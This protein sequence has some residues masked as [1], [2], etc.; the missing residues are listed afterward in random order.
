MIR[1]QKER[2]LYSL[3][4]TYISSRTSPNSCSKDTTRGGEEEGEAVCRAV[5][6]AKRFIAVHARR[7]NGYSS[8][9]V[10]IWKVIQ[11]G[12]GHLNETQERN[13]KK[14]YT[15]KVNFI[16]PVRTL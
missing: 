15:W 1:G 16:S 2:H 4:E 9:A 8:A 5:T 6:R 3:Y 7:E 11:N 14:M 10:L 13:M 12:G